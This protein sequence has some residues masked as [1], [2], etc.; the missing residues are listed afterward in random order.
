M[1]I[2]VT[3][4]DGYIGSRLAPILISHGHDI[5]GFDTGFYNSSQLYA[6]E[7]SQFKTIKKDIR[8]ITDADLEG[9]DCVVHLA[10]L[11]NDPL[12]QLNKQVTYEINHR[13]SVALA[14]K[15]KYN[16]ISQ[17]IYFS[18]CSVYGADGYSSF[19]TEDSQP[20]PLTAYAHCK[21]LV[22]NDVSLLA[23]DHFSPTFLRN[24]TAYG[25]SP[26][27]RFDIVVNNLCG[28]AWTEGEIKLNSDGSPW[29]PL[30]HVEDISAAVV[31]VLKSPREHIHNQ[32]LNVG[33]TSEN[34]QIKNIAEIILEVFPDS[35]LDIN[36]TGH[37][38]RSY[39]VSFEKIQNIL[40]DFS[41]EWDL[42]KG[43]IQLRDLFSDIPLSKNLFELNTFTRLK[44]IKRLLA[45]KAI[46]ETLYWT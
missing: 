14:K 19:K 22:E 25:P 44:Q 45:I 36:M 39:R 4:T 29:R 13:A 2:L 26:K 7:S 43:V 38:D 1:R 3:G 35:K 34:Y 24:A 18:S 46:D 11:S 33:C 28:M 37:D 12:G 9:F 21:V 5:T 17:F 32:I 27:M 10:E 8:K 41:P 42:Y 40:P 20:N 31:S 6:P 16:G 30:V 23:D 15:C